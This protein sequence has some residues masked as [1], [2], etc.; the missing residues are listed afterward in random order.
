M[1]SE[2]EATRLWQRLFRGQP[3]TN[4]TLAEAE[5]IV[6]SLSLESP[7]RLRLAVELEELRQREPP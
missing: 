4:L 1:L 5:T 2:E 6:E 3:I 7:V